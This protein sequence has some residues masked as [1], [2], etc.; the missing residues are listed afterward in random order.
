MLEIL[1]IAVVLN[2][3]LIL[4]YRKEHKLVLR[5]KRNLRAVGYK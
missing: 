2:L 4:M 1:I 3:V 5:V